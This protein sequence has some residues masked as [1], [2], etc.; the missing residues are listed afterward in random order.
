MTLH[1]S[2]RSR[3]NSN[4]VLRSKPKKPSASGFVAQTTK[5]PGETDTPPPR[6]QHVSPSSS[7]TRSSS[8]IMPPLDLVNLR[9]NLVNTVYSS[10]VV[11]CWCPKCYPLRLVFQTSWSLSPSLTPILHCS[12][13]I[14]TVRL[15]LTSTIPVDCL[16]A[17][18][19]HQYSQ[20]TCYTHVLT[21]W[22]ISKLNQNRPSSDNHSS[23]IRHTRTR[24]NHLHWRE[25][26][27]YAGVT[28][29]GHLFKNSN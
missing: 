6:C 8:P 16:C 15:Y 18:H 29:L 27:V 22:L 9:L 1:A 12:S 19:L 11:V 14:D 4:R 28:N 13:S 21:P 23:Q 7:T 3:R 25:T 20:D 2:S 26:T 10:C 24:I 5:P 17:P